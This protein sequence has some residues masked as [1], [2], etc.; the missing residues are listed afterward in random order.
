V[1]VP[2]QRKILDV[3]LTEMADAPNLVIIVPCLDEELMLP[4]TADVLERVLDGLVFGGAVSDNSRILFVDDGST[5]GTWQQICQLHRDQQRVEAIRLATNRGQQIAMLAGY[6][7]TVDRFDLFVTMDADL[8]DDP[9]AI[10]ALVSAALDGSELV[11]ATRRSRDR[12]SL[13]KRVSALAFYRL[14]RALGVPVERNQA[15]FRLMSRRVVRRLLEHNE[16]EIFLRSAVLSL[17]R[18]VTRVEVDRGRRSRG[19]SKYSVHRMFRLALNGIFSYSVA[20]LR[21]VSTLG[22]ALGLLSAPVVGY[23]LV[24]AALGS[25]VQGWLSLIASLYLLAGL[26][27]FSLGIVGEYVARLMIEVKGRPRYAI[28]E[29][30]VEP[31]SL[32]GAGE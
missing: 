24:S 17:T 9:A 28:D 18:S 1:N 4:E 2:D 5:D 11:L 6:E 25:T 21:L 20:P 12:D 15:D 22:A 29:V 27:L 19:A 16:R 32:E 7:H 8:E 26:I 30:L 13:A 31:A 23:L 10:P 3:W 14:A